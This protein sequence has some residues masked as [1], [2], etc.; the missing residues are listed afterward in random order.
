MDNGRNATMRRLVYALVGLALLPALALPAAAQMSNMP[1]ELRERLA[2]I[3]PTWGRD[4][5]ATWR[6]RLRSILRF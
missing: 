4:I 3:N 1:E 2:E 5:L 6:K